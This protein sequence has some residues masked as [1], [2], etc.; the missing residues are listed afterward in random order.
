ME[1]CREISFDMKV[2]KPNPPCECECELEPTSAPYFH[3]YCKKCDHFHT[4]M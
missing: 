2:T 3:A 4:L 1:S